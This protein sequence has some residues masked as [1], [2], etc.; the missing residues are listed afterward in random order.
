M[1]KVLTYKTHVSHWGKNF[2][3][4]ARLLK[5]RTDAALEDTSGQQLTE[6]AGWIVVIVVIILAAVAYCVPQV[7]T[8]LLPALSSKILNMINYTG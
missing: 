4:K 2:L 3:A 8:V 7:R 1:N 6:H 5:G